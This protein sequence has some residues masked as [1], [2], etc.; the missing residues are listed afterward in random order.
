MASSTSVARITTLPDESRDRFERYAYAAA[1]IGCVGQVISIALAHAA[2]GVAL[3]CLALSRKRLRTPP[4]MVPLI[5]FTIWSLLS[6]AASDDPAAGWPQV[7]KLALLLAVPLIVYSLFRTAGQIR[8]LMEGLFVAML[9]SSLTAIVQFIWKVSEAWAGGYSFIQGYEGRRITGFYSH[10]ITFS[11]VLLLLTLM[12]MAYVLL[13]GRP[14][15]RGLDVWAVVGAV[16]GLTVVLGY[17][18]SVWVAMIAGGAYLVWHW[19]PRLLWIAPAVLL[20]VILF[21]PGSVGLRL[22][23]FADPGSYDSR[24]V[25]WRTGARMIEAHPWFGVGLERVGRRFDEFQPKDVVKRPL[26]YYGHLHNLVIHYAAE[27]GIPAALF[28]IWFLLKVLWDHAAAASRAEARSGAQGIRWLLH[29]VAAATMGLIIA[30]LSDIAL[31]DSEVLGV[32]LTLV[33][34]GYRGIEL[35]GETANAA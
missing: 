5:G 22:H 3:A 25:M 30:G 34:I 6:L 8:R 28:M 2:L 26:G 11:E 20:L 18:R 23:S 10:W 19:R 35:S 12:M 31:G 9:A 24:I 16:L 4:V 32:Y 29:G 33:A 15:R 7:K 1:F 13:T 27:R 17:T 21:A 14:D